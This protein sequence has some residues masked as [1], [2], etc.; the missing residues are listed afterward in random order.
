MTS[1]GAGAPRSAH[2]AR[3]A[4]LTC[5]AVTGV[6]SMTIL[7][8]SGT[9]WRSTAA[10]AAIP[11]SAAFCARRIPASSASDFARRRNAKVSWSGVSVRPSARRRSATASGKS[12]STSASRTPIFAIAREISSSSIWSR[13]IPLSSSSKKPT[14][15]HSMISA[16]GRTAA[17]RSCSSELVRMNARPPT[18]A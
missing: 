9:A 1:G 2:A 4:A 11:A 3:S 17:I 10:A 13:G 8:P 18:S 6:P 15:A 7:S 12:G 5:S 14:S 16:S